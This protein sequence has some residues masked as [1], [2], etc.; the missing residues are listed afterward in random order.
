MTWRERAPYWLRNARCKR[1]CD[2]AEDAEVS[3]KAAAVLGLDAL[4]A[5]HARTAMRY[6]LYAL[7]WRPFEVPIQLPQ[8]GEG[9]SPGQESLGVATATSMPCILC[10]AAIPARSDATPE[11]GMYCDA[12]SGL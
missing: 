7:L 11:G 2:A 3:M 6:Y 4:T 1:W 12:C 8:P 10:G 5:A 9:S